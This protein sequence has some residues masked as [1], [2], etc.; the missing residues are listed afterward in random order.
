MTTIKNSIKLLLLAQVC[1][2]I[3]GITQA[4]TKKKAAKT[5]SFTK[6]TITTDFISEGAT[7]A[8][9]NKDGKMDILAGA[10][11]FEAPSWKAHEITQPQA[12]DYKTWY[13]NSFLNYSMD[14]NQDG[15]MDLI[16][17]G[18]PGKEV[19]WYENPKNK[20]GHWKEH[21]I[22]ATQGN[23]SPMLVDIDGD[24]RKDFLCNDPEAKQVIWLKSPK[25]GSTEWIKTVIS[26]DPNLA[27]HQYTHGLGI[28]DLNGDKR[29]D[30]LVKDGWWEAPK[31]PMESNWKFHKT[32]LSQD[33]SQMHVID[34]NGD[35]LADIISSSAHAYGIWWHEQGKDAQGNMTWTHHEI[36]KAFSQTHGTELKDINGDGHPDIVTGKRYFAHNGNDPGAHDGAVIYWFEYVPGKVPSWIPHQIDDNSGVGLHV[37]VVDM[38]RDGAP[39]IVVG[40]KKGVHYHEQKRK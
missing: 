5:V 4:Q 6:Q 19:V 26:S 34:L 23:E 15:W 12:F 36:S 21:M 39:D 14:V 10:F 9:V 25:K 28:G 17:V 20:P 7:A 29:P 8:D 24:G 38:N 27:T 33:C 32:D 22:Y 1:L 2:A 11:W 3:P 13:S 37:T 31:N 40:N 30:V 35:G 16:R 18:F